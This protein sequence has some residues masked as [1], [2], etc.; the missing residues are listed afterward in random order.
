[1]EG[2]LCPAVFKY[3]DEALKRIYVQAEQHTEAG[4]SVHGNVICKTAPPRFRCVR[5]SC[6]ILSPD[7]ITAA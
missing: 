2:W 1:M 4:L 5:R 6:R 3:F 7:S